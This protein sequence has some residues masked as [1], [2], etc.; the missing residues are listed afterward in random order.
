MS[1]AAIDLRVWN[2]TLDACP[3]SAAIVQNGYVLAGQHGIWKDVETITLVV[4]RA[5]NLQC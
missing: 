1:C 4:G 3:N 5:E 2:Y